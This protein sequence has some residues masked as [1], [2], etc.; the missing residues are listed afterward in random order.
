MRKQAFGVLAD[1]YAKK[2]AEMFVER[3]LFRRRSTGEIIDKRYLE[4]HYPYHYRYNI[5]HGLKAMA[6]AGIV[7]DPRCGDRSR[8][9]IPASGPAHDHAFSAACGCDHRQPCR[10]IRAAFGLVHSLRRQVERLIS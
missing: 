1:W 6:E 3:K 7:R 2:A 5:L 9:G 10:G 8:L 4:L